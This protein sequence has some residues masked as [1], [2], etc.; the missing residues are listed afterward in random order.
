MP[1]PVATPA[2]G[3]EPTATPVPGPTATPVQAV[4]TATP[5]PTPVPTPTPTPT[6]TPMAVVPVV[7]MPDDG[8]LPAW[9][10]P[11][12]GV[13]VLGAALAGFVIVNATRRPRRL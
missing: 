10:L 13:L 7:E 2:P 6:A 9:V 5:T 8:G 11:V 4:Q 12:A 3:P 1:E